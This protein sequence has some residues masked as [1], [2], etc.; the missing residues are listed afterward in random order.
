VRLELDGRH[1]VAYREASANVGGA[2]G[3]DLADGHKK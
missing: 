2:I 3:I 1:F